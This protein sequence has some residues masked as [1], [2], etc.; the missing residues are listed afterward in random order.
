[1]NEADRKWYFA[2]QALAVKTLGLPFPD[3]TI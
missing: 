3:V 2:V 1:M